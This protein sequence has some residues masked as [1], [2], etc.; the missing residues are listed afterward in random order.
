[1]LFS[2]RFLKIQRGED[3]NVTFFNHLQMFD[4][5]KKMNYINTNTVYLLPHSQITSIFVISIYS[6]QSSWKIKIEDS[7][8]V[9]MEM[10]CKLKLYFLSQADGFFTTSA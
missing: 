2:G 4:P 7:E 6:K 3:I 5:V 10:K 1:L 8:C 9:T